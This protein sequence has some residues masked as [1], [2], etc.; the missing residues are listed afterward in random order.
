MSALVITESRNRLGKRDGDEFKREASRMWSWWA[1]QENIAD[2]ALHDVG[3]A[4]KAEKQSRVLG[5]ISSVRALDRVAFFCHGTSRGISLGFSVDNIAILADALAGA[6]GP[7]LH[8]GLYACLTGRGAFFGGAKNKKNT[9]YRCESV[10]T[11][12]EGFAMLLCS[13]LKKRG[14]SAEITAHLTSGHTTKN[15]YKV[16]VS[17]TNGDIMRVRLCDNTPRDKWIKWCEKLDADPVF[18]YTIMMED[19]KPFSMSDYL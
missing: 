6:A 14:V 18:R 17:P 16:R 15:P 11:A 13:E 4:S 19:A 8:V 10:V 1:E 5:A 9:G 2:C 3:T 12:R 7:V